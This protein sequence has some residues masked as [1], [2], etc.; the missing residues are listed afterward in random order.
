MYSQKENKV[1][2]K[3]KIVLEDINLETLRGVLDVPNYVLLTNLDVSSS[4]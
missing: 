3:K 1:S 4:M 2:H